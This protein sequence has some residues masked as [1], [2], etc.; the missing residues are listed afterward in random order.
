[1]KKALIRRVEPAEESDRLFKRFRGANATLI[2]D[3]ISEMRKAGHAPFG[4]SA[5][6]DHANQLDPSDRMKMEFPTT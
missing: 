5:T 1:M 2:Q 4:I 6:A 3:R